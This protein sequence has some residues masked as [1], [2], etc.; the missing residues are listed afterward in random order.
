MLICWGLWKFY[1]NL[2][3]FF[4]LWFH[5]NLGGRTWCQRTGRRGDIWSSD[6]ICPHLY[7]PRHPLITWSCLMAHEGHCWVILCSCPIHLLRFRLSLLFLQH[8][9]RGHTSDSKP[10]PTAGDSSETGPPR[11]HKITWGPSTSSPGAQA[12][13]ALCG[14]GY[15]YVSLPSL[16]LLSSCFLPW[17]TLLGE[18]GSD[19]ERPEGFLS[20]E[21]SQ[22]K[23]RQPGA[24]T[25][26]PCIK[27][28]FICRDT[29][30]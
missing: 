22:V 15:D 29:K 21:A 6:V 16:I 19:T 13:K 2:F 30:R 28:T 8:H 4:S 11:P 18:A 5:H 24:N 26:M 10:L 23:L 3:D 27:V 7:P 1:F 12:G 20:T 9:S 25:P 17:E 14:H